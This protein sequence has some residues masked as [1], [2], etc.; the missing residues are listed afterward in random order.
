LGFADNKLPE[1]GRIG[2]F[3]RCVNKNASISLNQVLTIS[4]DSILT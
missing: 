3:N 1:R 4:S 2:I